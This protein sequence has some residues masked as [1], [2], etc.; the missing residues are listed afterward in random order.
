[1]RSYKQDS[2]SRRLCELRDDAFSA[3]EVAHQRMERE[4]MIYNNT[5]YENERVRL[6]SLKPLVGESFDPRVTSA[7]NRLIPAYMQQLP[8]IEVFPDRHSQDDLAIEHTGIIEDW[9][10]MMNE[11][12]DEQ[13]R[14]R[15]MVH[16][17]LIM[18]N[19]IGKVYWDDGTGCVRAPMIDPMT[20]APDPKGANVDFSDS[21]YVAHCNDHLGRVIHQKYGLRMR[22]D[23]STYRV[24]EIWLRRD[25]ADWAGVDVSG[26]KAQV[27][28]ATLI[29]DRVFRVM[30]NPNWYPGFP[31]VAWRNFHEL[32]D[33]KAQSFWGFGYGSL[34]WP[35]QKL[36]DELWANVVLITRNIAV[37]RYMTTKGT[38]DTDQ[39][40]AE[41]GLVI[42]LLDNKTL[43][44]IEHLS[45]EEI[46][47]SLFNM[48]A[49]VNDR[50]NE[51]VPSNTPAFVG[52]APTADASGKLAQTL[53][54]AAYSQLSDNVAGMTQCRLRRARI[55]IA[56]IQQNAER[57]VEPYKWR[58]GIDI[59]D[60]FPED[61]RFVGCH[62]SVRD[63]TMFP[64][65]PQG[66]LQ[67]V[68]MLAMVGVQLNPE[69]YIELLQLDQELGIRKSD[70]MMQP[71]MD[72]AQ[73]QAA[74][75]QSPQPKM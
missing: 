30:E 40:L 35:D 6:G 28:L 32:I 13:S 51:Q 59:P 68:Q 46:P 29:N 45:P 22:S 49:L 43:E 58:Y 62:P 39:I 37:G 4:L 69:K 11:V 41:H 75:G 74:G 27:V 9:L 34:L 24:D 70:I 52:E 8:K 31:F 3:S 67:A 57:P 20:F 7:V 33:G 55:K 38:L 12:D 60:Q 1:M 17:N 48:I 63:M 25:I 10:E 47:A 56:V 65:T 19:A 66:R 72:E 23:D 73:M 5:A 21:D 14:L 61:A 26:S 42:E 16:H 54:E 64:N 50:M 18:G 2:A 71:M 15:T 44:D 36:L 53:Q